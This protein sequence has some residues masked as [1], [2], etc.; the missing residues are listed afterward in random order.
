MKKIIS[1]IL[2]FCFSLGMVFSQDSQEK[3]K[4]KKDRPVREAWGSGFII[5]EQT[6]FTHEKKSLETQIQ[7]RFGLINKNG[8]SDLYGIYAPSANTRIGFAYSVLDN[9]EVGYGITRIN[10]MSDLRVKY[11]FLRQTRKNT[12]PLSVGVFAVM[13]IDG[14]NKSTFSTVTADSAYKF[15]NRMSFFTQLILDRKFNDMFSLGFNASFTHYNT[16]AADSVGYSGQ[17]HDKIGVGLFAR[18][19]F[20]PQSSIIL[21]YSMPLNIKSLDEHAIVTNS[22][23]ANFGIGYQVA[24]ASHAFEVFFTTST[25]LLPQQ[26]YMWNTNDWTKGEFLIGF[27]ITRFWGF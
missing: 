12:I 15:T 19:K 18:I 9:L 22:P 2:V 20:S 23:K 10:M 6:T 25:G 13:G 26:N 17:N 16:V 11:T 24:T 1:I 14:R 3:P 7:H 5:D 21:H 4:K 27:N 8:I